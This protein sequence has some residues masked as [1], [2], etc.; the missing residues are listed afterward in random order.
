MN[1]AKAQPRN[2]APFAAIPGGCASFK[3][4]RHRRFFGRMCLLA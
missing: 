3:D 1:A 2:P 4:I